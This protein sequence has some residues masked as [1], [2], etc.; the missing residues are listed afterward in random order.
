M[1][2][3]FPSRAVA[4]S[5]FGWQIHWY[6]LLYLAAFLVAWWLL[7][8]LQRFRALQVS[9]DEWSRLLAAGV[10]GV[11][12]GGRLGYVLL[13]APGYY[14]AHPVE[15]LAVWR[16][17]MSSHGGM[18][19]VAV[20]L[21]WALR[22]RTMED[23]WAVADSI[24]IPAAIGL[25]FGRIGNF[26]NLEVYG[27]VT[28]LPWGIAIPGV[29][30]LRHPTQLYA[31]A[32]DLLI[33]SVCFLHVRHPGSLPGR[34]FALFLIMY[35]VLRFLLEFLRDQPYGVLAFG[36]FTL[37]PGQVLTIPVFLIGAGVW[38]WVGRHG[39]DQ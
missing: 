12:I 36:F 5:L 19:G 30:G 8:R 33:A 16:G 21:W 14:L 27:T 15:I 31:V 20:A 10:L 11:L 34:T 4:L 22:H 29:E 18:I 9:A 3:L 37:T 7:P 24:V 32:K 39:N 23:R 35:G 13:Y 6:G 26:I 1:I 38:W 2:E 25:A 17:G 28:T